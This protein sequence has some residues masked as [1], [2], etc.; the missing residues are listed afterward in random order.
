MDQYDTIG[1]VTDAPFVF[2]FYENTTRYERCFVDAAYLAASIDAV[3]LQHVRKAHSMRI[4]YNSIEF[5]SYQKKVWYNTEEAFCKKVPLK[6]IST[7]SVSFTAP[8]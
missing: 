5:V 6:C 2:S 7:K 8:P 4:V 3:L 1:S